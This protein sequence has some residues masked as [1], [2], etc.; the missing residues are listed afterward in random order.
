MSTYRERREAKAERLRGWADANQARS[1]AALGQASQ[2]AQAIPFGQ[3]ILVGHHSER[4]DRN[5]RARIEGTARRGLDL[6][7]KA[8]NQTR[9]ADEIERQADQAIYDDDPDAIE[10]LTAKIAGLEAERARIK[11]YN[12]DARKA[13][14]TGRAP[15]ADLLD[16]AQQRH[17]LTLVRIGHLGKAGTFPPYVAANLS[18]NI[19]RLRK[20]LEGLQR[21][22]HL[23]ERTVPNK[24]PG[25]CEDCGADVP[26][27]AGVARGRRGDFHVF[28]TDH[29]EAQP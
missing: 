2:M 27:Y 22:D 18:G 16:E 28:C 23:Q 6:G 11:A 21:G 13:D 10:R 5:Y 4:R 15:D 29:Q 26:A 12:A 17:L 8:T 24:Y 9:R 25:V 1:D 3:P 20:R 7:A 14:R 19:S